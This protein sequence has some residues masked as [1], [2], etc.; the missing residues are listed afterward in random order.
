VQEHFPP[1]RFLVDL[2]NHNGRFVIWAICEECNDDTRQF[3]Q[4]LPMLK[5]MNISVQF[6]DG[7]DP[8]SIYRARSNMLLC[9]WY[10]AIERND[11][12]SAIAASQEALNLYAALTDCCLSHIDKDVYQ[13]PVKKPRQRFSQKHRSRRHTSVSQLPRW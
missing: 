1:K 11:V 3:I 6:R 5:P 10:A 12:S 7:V 4:E 13:T 9:D 2:P 8:W